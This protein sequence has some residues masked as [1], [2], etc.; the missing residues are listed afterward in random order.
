MTFLYE[1]LQKTYR[2]DFV[3]FRMMYPRLLFP[4]TTPLDKSQETYMKVPG[5]RLL[6][7]LHPWYW[8]KTA[9][10]IRR[11][12]PDLIL[13]DWYQPFFGPMY[14][15]IG[16]LLP[17][18]LRRR[19]AFI[20]E[21][22]ISHEA[23]RVDYFLTRLGLYWGQGYIALSAKVATDLGAFVGRK[24]ILRSELPIFSGYR[25]SAATREAQQRRFGL[26][27]GARTLLF[28]GYIR[29]Y[30][31]LDLLLEALALLL[32]ED[33]RY[34]LLIAGECYED[35]AIYRRLIERLGLQDH[36]YFEHAYIDNESVAEWFCAAD[37]VILPYR[38]ATQSGILN[39]A[40]G[41]EKPVVTTNVGGLGEF[42]EDEGTGI[43]VT[44][45]SAPALAGG[46]RR[47]YEV[48][49]THDFAA[50]IHQRVAG[51]AF[52]KINEVVEA[53]RLRM[54]PD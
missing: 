53:L 31:G 14:F 37:V 18:R 23:R 45:A 5:P 10:H 52:G 26:P 2:V 54:Q 51:N 22:V 33:P 49:E 36:V 4:G 25:P 12:D 48:A 41:F 47:F 32:P 34:R 39:M 20:A 7:S 42:V 19:M 13:F 35:P 43:L 46:I 16:L 38:S 27:V 17:S 6:H 21:N 24:P 8:W 28:F 29:H 30:K 44:E 3:N 15:G 50:A 1:A 9:R 11:L 40:Y